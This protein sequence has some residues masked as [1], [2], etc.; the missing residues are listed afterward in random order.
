MPRKT[1]WLIVLLAVLAPTMR[2]IADSDDDDRKPAATDS[3]DSHFGLFGLL[4][5]RS[6]RNE[7]AGVEPRL[8][9]RQADVLGLRVVLV[10]TAE[11]GPGR[12]HERLRLRWRQW[13]R[14]RR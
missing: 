4:D 3:G 14:P 6:S 2:V 13:L 8:L 9:D 10:T 12:M 11:L 1:F 5:H 7:L